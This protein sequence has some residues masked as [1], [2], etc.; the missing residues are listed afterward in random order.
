ME[1]TEFISAVETVFDK[2]PSAIIC[3]GKIVK[4]NK[5]Y[6]RLINSVSSEAVCS[7]A[8]SAVSSPKGIFS[9]V[10]DFSLLTAQAYPMNGSD[11][12]CVVFRS[13]H[14]YNLKNRPAVCI[15]DGRIRSENEAF[16]NIRSSNDPVKLTDLVIRTAYSE[17]G[18][19]SAVSGGMNYKG[20]TAAKGDDDSFLVVVYENFLFSDIPKDIIDNL[21]T[22]T[23]EVNTS[24]QSVNDC[25][26]EMYS[27]L[28]GNY[29]DSGINVS[30]SPDSIEQFK[31]NLNQIDRTEVNLL[32]STRL[33]EEVLLY[34]TNSDL[35]R[36]IKMSEFADRFCRFLYEAVNDD[37]NRAKLI[38]NNLSKETDAIGYFKE[39][40]LVML[41]SALISYVI[42]KD[43][44]CC[45]RF[46]LQITTKILDDGKEY[47]TLNAFLSDNPDDNK[48]APDN[49]GKIR[50]PKDFAPAN[51]YEALL[52]S[53]CARF[54]CSVNSF[55][56]SGNIH[57]FSGLG[58][59]IP[60]CRKAGDRVSASKTKYIDNSWKFSSQRA[61][62]S[63]QLFRKKYL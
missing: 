4:Y 39:D 25:T 24:I 21:I 37:E 12:F 17:T 55:I 43:R 59:I 49:F 2:I 41:I 51:L 32:G 63:K 9:S 16:K 47:I 42:E 56:L 28:I 62:L 58:I 10:T 44:Q 60:L 5:E 23:A 40:T 45:K 15:K 46:S 53:F 3:S 26:D 13:D 34:S 52:K 7:A 54:G 18:T 50:F 6:E 36:E 8:V 19:F 27:L 29:S 11:M 35:G 20:V 38:V 33:L 1:Q 57:G 48:A 30:L 31:N 14:D 22:L 61:L